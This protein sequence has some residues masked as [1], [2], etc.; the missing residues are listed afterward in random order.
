MLLSKAYTFIGLAIAVVTSTTV[1][2]QCVP[3]DQLEVLP[4]DPLDSDQPAWETIL[5][6]AFPT[7]SVPTNGC[8]R[9]DS[10]GGE[11]I[12]GFTEFPTP[13][14]GKFNP[15]YYTKAFAGLDPKLG[16]YPSPVDT[17]YVYEFAAPYER[18]PGDGSVHH[19]NNNDDL[20]DIGAPTC[21]KVRSERDTV[22]SYDIIIIVLIYSSIHI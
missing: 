13:E 9:L 18:Q 6:I 20:Q 15:C 16:G 12:D 3:D 11:L 10:L 21:P 2:A 8:P 4:I 22:C 14:D 19:C 5:E 7:W 1:S 17:K